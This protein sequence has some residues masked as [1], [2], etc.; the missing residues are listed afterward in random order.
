[1]AYIKLNKKHFFHNLDL[2]SEQTSHKDKIAIVLKDNAYGHGLIEMANLAQEYGIIHAVVRTNA[3]ASQIKEHFQTLLVLADKQPLHPI[4]NVHLA[5]NDL[6]EL[7]SMVSHSNIELKIDTGMHR[8]GLHI[9]E[10]E[11][12]FE[13]IKEKQLS[14]KGI[15][16]HHRSADVLS[17]EYFWQEK[18]F[19]VI[20]QK[21]EKLLSQYHMPTIRYHSQNS[22][23]TFR[24]QSSGDIVRVGIA[25]FGLLEMPKSLLN[26]E[27]K[28]VLSLWA[29]KLHSFKSFKDAKHGYEGKGLIRDD[30]MLSTYNI[31]YADGL[32]RLQDDVPYRMVNGSSLIGRISMDNIIVDCEDKDLCIYND[33]RIYAKTASTISYE[34]TTRLASHLQRTII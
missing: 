24:T 33:A 19:E 18:Q 12:A 29:D 17:S 6:A 30:K 9:D 22:A 16:T 26:L 13:I 7:T 10:L 34:V 3:E 4:K 2:I 31:G 14:L 1:M 23:A 28:P 20:K 21:S 15:F 5:I 11:R 25:A 27:F 8:N 32:L